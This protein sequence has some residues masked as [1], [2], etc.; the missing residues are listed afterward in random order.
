MKSTRELI[1]EEIFMKDGNLKR[2]NVVLIYCTES[3]VSILVNSSPI[4][5][6]LP[7][8]GHLP[9]DKFK[10]SP[11]HLSA[12]PSPTNMVTIT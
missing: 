7:L 4:N 9:N 12:P 11:Y 6:G 8:C 1:N 10:S 2:E 5:S 3:V